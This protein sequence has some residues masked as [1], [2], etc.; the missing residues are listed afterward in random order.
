MPF[1]PFPLLSK[2]LLF[3]ECEPWQSL[4][5]LQNAQRES[6]LDIPVLKPCYETLDKT[7]W[8]QGGSSNLL[9]TF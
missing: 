2:L 7:E 1:L 8:T 5:H 3:R 6:S 9:S 4:M